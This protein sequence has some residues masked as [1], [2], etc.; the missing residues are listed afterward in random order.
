[1]FPVSPV[2]L[3]PCFLLHGTHGCDRHPA[4][5]APSAREEG[6]TRCKTRTNHVARMRVLEIEARNKPGV[7]LA[8]ARR[9][10]LPQMAVVARRQDRIPLTTMLGGDGSWLSPGR[11]WGGKPQ[12]ACQLAKL[13]SQSH[14]TRQ[15]AARTAFPA[16]ESPFGNLALTMIS[17]WLGSECRAE[18]PRFDTLA[19]EAGPGFGRASHATD[20]KGSRAD[21]A[22]ARGCGTGADL[23][24]ACLGHLR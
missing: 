12:C 21:I 23:R 3:P 15:P 5:P 7:V 10:P 14:G 4:F 17:V 13:A 6:G 9:D 22:A 11:R 18:S 16:P 24:P 1:M 8:Q 20:V 19:G 2:V